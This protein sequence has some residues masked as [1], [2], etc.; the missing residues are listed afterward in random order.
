ML[1]LLFYNIGMGYGPSIALAGGVVASLPT[2]CQNKSTGACVSPC[3]SVCPAGTP[4]CKL[5]VSFE[6]NVYVS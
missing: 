2:F 1:N 3:T 6:M 4:A 5:L